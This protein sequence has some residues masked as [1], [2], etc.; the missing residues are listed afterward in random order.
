M[1]NPLVDMEKPDLIFAIGTNMTEC[2]PVAAL[3]LKKA[4]KRGENV[5]RY[6]RV[7]YCR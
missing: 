3:R 6:W 5:R 7:G 2:H 1:S 4:I